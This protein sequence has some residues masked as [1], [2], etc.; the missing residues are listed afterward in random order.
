LI[1]VA[2]GKYTTYRIMAKDAVDLAASRL[3]MDVLPSCTHRLPLLGAD[4]YPALC[5]RRADLAREAGLSEA[6]VGRLLDRYG[7]QCVDLLTLIADRPELGE[8][9][10]GA[11]TYLR[12]E[13]LYAATHEGALHL[14]DLLTRRTRISIETTD[15]GIRAARSV[16]ELVA[17]ALGWSSQTRER[18]IAHYE[19]RVAAERE[20]QEQLDD[21]TADAARLG[22]PD[23]RR[24][25]VAS[26]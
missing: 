4:G 1:S 7:S 18:E 13:A 15:R 17:D 14:D 20:S 6:S 10:E 21:Q 23:V 25:C 11:E 5:K 19:A 24:S 22:A 2:G 26:D 12:A 9:V 8:P 16:A 3:E